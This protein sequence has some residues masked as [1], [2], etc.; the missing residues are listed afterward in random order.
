MI[1]DKEQEAFSV[2][3]EHHQSG[4]SEND[5]RYAFQRFVETARVTTV[6]EM[7]TEAPP[8]IGNPGSMDLYFQSTCIEFKTNIVLGGLP[9]SEYTSRLD[10]YLETL[11]K[12]GTGVR[13][14]I[15]TDGVYYFLHRVGEE[16][17]P[18][19]P[20][21][22]MQTF[23]HAAQPSRLREYLCGI[24]TAPTENISPRQRTSKGI[25]KATPTPS[26]PAT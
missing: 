13:N 12:A 14:C 20:H 2:V 26:V 23:N 4:A 17:L 18:L 5:I 3:V 11:L 9:I 24:I 7:S 16:K 1:T 10:G 6:S 8:G 19:L 15:L 21:G 22:A 25:L